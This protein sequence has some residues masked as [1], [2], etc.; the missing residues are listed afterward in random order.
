MKESEGTANFSEFRMRPIH[1]IITNHINFSNTFN[2]PG[3][4]LLLPT[5]AT[6]VAVPDGL[7]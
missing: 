7:D 1:N 6:K 5:G 4:T 3:K 2:V